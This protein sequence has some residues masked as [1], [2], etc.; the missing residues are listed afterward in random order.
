MTVQNMWPLAF[1]VL[2]PI[3]ILLYILKQRAKDQTF[4]SILL[5]QEIYKNLEARTPF[6]KLKHKKYD[7]M[8]CIH[9]LTHQ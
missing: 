7:L 4:S 3:I 8:K 6:E 9:K 2:I 5:W 1:C